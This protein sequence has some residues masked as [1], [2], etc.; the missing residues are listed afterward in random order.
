MLGAST[1]F[2]VGFSI[3]IVLLAVL[4]GF[5]ISFAVRIARIGRKDGGGAKRDRRDD[6]RE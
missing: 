5:V 6:S 3:F 2:F 4:F 1:G